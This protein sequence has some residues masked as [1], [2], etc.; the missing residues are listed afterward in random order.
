M[1][2]DLKNALSVCIP[3]LLVA[4]LYYICYRCCNHH[5]PTIQE[6]TQSQSTYGATRDR[7]EDLRI[8]L[9]QLISILPESQESPKTEENECIVC[10]ERANQITLLPCQHLLCSKCSMDWVTER[11]TCPKCVKLVNNFRLKDFVEID[12]SGGFQ[13]LK[14]LK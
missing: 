7:P 2:N 5:A 1:N 10:M 9:V 4:M 6:L 12:L 8:K 3:L 11:H 13:H 14:T